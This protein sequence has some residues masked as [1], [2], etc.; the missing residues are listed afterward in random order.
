[1]PRQR[2]KNIIQSIEFLRLAGLCDDGE[3]DDDDDDDGFNDGC[4]RGEA[5]EG[6]RG[7]MG[8]AG[9]VW[10]RDLVSSGLP[11][12]SRMYGGSNLVADMVA[13]RRE[14]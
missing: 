12:E 5:D 10:E 1:M 3:D 7:P 13:R 6:V 9:S 2:P 14:S 4:W 11:A 8:K